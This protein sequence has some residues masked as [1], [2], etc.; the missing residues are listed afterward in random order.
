MPPI[1]SLSSCSAIAWLLI[2]GSSA[3]GPAAPAIQLHCTAQMQAPLCA[4]LTASLQQRFPDA[5]VSVVDGHN[6][7]VGLT[8]R[9]LPQ[10]QEQTWMS[11]SLTWRH[12]D[13]RHGEGPVIEHSVMDGSLTHASLEDFAGQLVQHTEFPL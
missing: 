7:A 10:H 12:S 8:L 3:F 9:Y 5:D 13:G 2:S 4:A 1:G 11:G 6:G